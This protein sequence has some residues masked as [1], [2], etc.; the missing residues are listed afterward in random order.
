MPSIKAHD[1]FHSIPSLAS[2]P[3]VHQGLGTY[4]LELGVIAFFR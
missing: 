4:G 1:P 3:A 2:T